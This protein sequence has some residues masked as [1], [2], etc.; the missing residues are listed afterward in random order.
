M[1]A[2]EGRRTWDDAYAVEVDA[3]DERSMRLRGVHCDRMTATAHRPSIV[4]CVCACVCKDDGRKEYENI[5][6]L[7]LAL[8]DRSD[9]E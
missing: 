9:C 8:P 6:T 2:D 7:Q 1:Q 5:F 3:I 4:L